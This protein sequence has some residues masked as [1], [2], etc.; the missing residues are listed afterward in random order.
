MALNDLFNLRQPGDQAAEQTPVDPFKTKVADYQKQI[1]MIQQ[2]AQ[3]EAR[4][5]MTD[6]VQGQLNSLTGHDQAQQSLMQ[7]EAANALQTL[8][9]QQ[10]QQAYPAVGDDTTASLGIMPASREARIR[11]LDYNDDGTPKF[12]YSNVDGKQTAI[13]P[14]KATRSTLEKS[15]AASD[16]SLQDAIYLYDNFKDDYFTYGSRAKHTGQAYAEKLF[17]RGEYFVSPEEAEAKAAY[18]QRARTAFFNWV[19]E[20]SGAQVS[21]AEMERRQTARFNETMS[22][23]QARAGLLNMVQEAVIKRQVIKQLLAEGYTLDSRLDHKRMKKLI[24][25][26]KAFH[27]KKISSFTDRFMKANP[28]AT[29]MDALLFYMQKNNLLGAGGQ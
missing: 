22:P 25:A 18:M 20:Q 23:S 5:K 21:D 1:Q 16:T 3:E 9:S 29:K 13:R 8:A 10:F 26:Q 12:V 15:L 11:K 2:Q 14:S 4:P 19:K 28:E 27:S 17:G 24:S 6:V 7:K